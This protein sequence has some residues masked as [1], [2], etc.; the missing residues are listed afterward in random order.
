MA[1]RRTPR[2]LKGMTKATCSTGV[3]LLAY[4]FRKSN[5]KQIRGGCREIPH[6]LRRDASYP[7]TAAVAL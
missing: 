1:A 7:G 2:D 3:L 5:A 6:G 4:P